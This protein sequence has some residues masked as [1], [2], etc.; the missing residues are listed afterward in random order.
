MVCFSFCRCAALLLCLAT[1]VRAD[2]PPLSGFRGPADVRNERPYQLLFLDFSPQE[3]TTLAA[4]RS[5]LSLHLDVGNDLLTPR[6]GVAAFPIAPL[7]VVE[8]TE[9]QRLTLAYRRGLDD[10]RTEVGVQTFLL[11]RDGGVLD[12]LLQRYHELTGLTH[13]SQDTPDGRHGLSF[14]HSTVFLRDG[15]GRVLVD[16][17]PAA[18]LG[19]TSLFVKRGLVSRPDFALSV[20]AGLKLPTGNAALLLGSGGVDGGLDLDLSERLSHR[21]ALFIDVG[22]IW[23]QKDRRIATAATHETQYAVGVEWLVRTHGSLVLQTEGGSR[24]VTTGIHHADVTPSLLT[25]AYKRQSGGHTIYTFAFTENGDIFEY[26]LPQLAGIGPDVTFSAGVEW[27][28]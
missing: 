24:A 18:G 5:R 3:G 1:V 15:S 17:H 8:D 16:A 19:D 7:T 12:P 23:M 10:G 27:Q 22:Q 4:G 14:Y 13:A 26:R 9:T 20:R 28:R 21:R 25:L 11:A 6:P 2:E